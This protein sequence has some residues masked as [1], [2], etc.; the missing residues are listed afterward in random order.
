MGCLR[1]RGYVGILFTDA[2]KTNQEN[3]MELFRMDNTEG[4]EQNELDMLNQ[5][6]ENIAQQNPD[7]EVKNIQ[8][9]L[10]NAY[11][12]DLDATLIQFRAQER[13]G[14]NS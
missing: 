9:A 4:F 2:V 14:I 5:V 6:A 10:N 8:D 12:K 7:I 13:L 11:V 1:N 3:E